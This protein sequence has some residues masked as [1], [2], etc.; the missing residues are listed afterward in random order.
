MS[1]NTGLECAFESGLRPGR[2]SNARSN[3]AY[4]S[5]VPVSVV[6]VRIVGVAVTQRLVGVSVR[7]R[8]AGR[9]RR[10]VV[11][12]VV[13]V[14]LVPMLVLQPLVNVLV[15]VALTDMEPDAEQHEGRG[16][17]EP[18]GDRLAQ[19]DHPDGGANERRC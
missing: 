16:Q 4:L 2:Y 8:L 11:M 10:V 7:V 14:V 17:P 5:S 6:E 18:R 9:R 3:A 1:I 15:L 13:L 12:V 19:H